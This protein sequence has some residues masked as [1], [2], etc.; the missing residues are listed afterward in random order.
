MSTSVVSIESFMWH[1]YSIRFVPNIDGFVLNDNSLAE[2]EHAFSMSVPPRVQ[3][4]N[5]MPEDFDLHEIVHRWA[6]HKKLRI[7]ADNHVVVCESTGNIYLIDYLMED[8]AGIHTIHMYYSPQR[9]GRRLKEMMTYVTEMKD[10]CQ[11]KMKI[12]VQCSII[13]VYGTSSPKT[14]TYTL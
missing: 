9:G 6:R 12:Q 1:P 5:T 3:D 8:E 11:N 7:V 14:Y 10:I 13:C 4:I 2:S